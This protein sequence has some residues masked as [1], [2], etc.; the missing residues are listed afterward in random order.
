MCGPWESDGGISTVEMPRVTWDVLQGRGVP[1]VLRPR[2]GQESGRGGGL[3]LLALPRRFDIDSM[4]WMHIL[5][6]PT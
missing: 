2:I 1:A 6:Q 3:E 4:S 5:C